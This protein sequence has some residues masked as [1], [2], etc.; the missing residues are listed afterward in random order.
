M[1][2][3]AIEPVEEIGSESERAAVN[4]DISQEK[5]R[6]SNVFSA[7]VLHPKLPFS[8]RVRT[9]RRVRFSSDEEKDVKEEI[10]GEEQSDSYQRDC[11][12]DTYP[13]TQQMYSK[14][15]VL[16]NYYIKVFNYL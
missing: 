5:V 13:S 11:L 1:A 8:P 15:Q 12:F 9:R 16:C 3:V 2:G 7:T 10:D 4:L 6:V 14:T